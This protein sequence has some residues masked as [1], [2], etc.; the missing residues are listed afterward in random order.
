MPLTSRFTAQLIAEHTNVPAAMDLAASVAQRFP[1]SISRDI[2]LGDGTGAG[3]ADR[4]FSD[5]RTTSG[6]DDLDLA[7]VLTDAFNATITFARIK[8]L[9]ILAADANGSNLVVGS[10]TNPL[11]TILGATSTL[12]VRPGGMFLWTC[13]AADATG[14]AVT[15]GTGDI[16]RIAS[17]GGSVTYDIG[18][19]GVSA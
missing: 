8:A 17:G 18:I 1:L 13:S 3:N 16:L 2:S 7:G 12:Q 11:T 6:N 4:L 5:R 10:G 15:A 14:A 9:I 19:V